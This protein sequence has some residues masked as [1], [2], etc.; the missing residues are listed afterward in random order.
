M[1][2]ERRAAVVAVMK[3]IQEDVA[4]DTSRR[5]GLPFTGATVAAAL[6]EICAQVGA[7][8][9]AIECILTEVDQ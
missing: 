2:P 5:E 3:M 8:A 1:T 4:A 7:L 6:G 9:H